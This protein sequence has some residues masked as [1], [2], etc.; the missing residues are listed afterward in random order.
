MMQN[1][2]IKGTFILGPLFSKWMGVFQSLL[3][4]FSIE[5]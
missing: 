2:E 5:E 3:D 1:Q 4:C